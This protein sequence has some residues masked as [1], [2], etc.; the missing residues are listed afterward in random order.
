MTE[1]KKTQPVVEDSGVPKKA[2]KKPARKTKTTSA[3]TANTPVEEKLVKEER[4]YQATDLI[5]CR[6]VF[7]GK[8]LMEG[9]KS[10]NTYFWEEFGEVNEV[11]YQDLISEMVNSRSDYLYGPLI[12]IMDEELV[13]SKP[14]LKNFYSQFTINTDQ[15]KKVLKS[16]N[17]NEIKNVLNTIPNTL[18][19]SVPNIVV[20]MIDEGEIRDPAV[21]RTIDKALGTDLSNNLQLLF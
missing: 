17:V 5:P 20:G 8:L 7:G 1:E 21:L 11:E 2:Q 13:N 14:K 4:V 12:Y 9:R 18:A 3:K 19:Q 6:N 15:L 10:K 16:Q